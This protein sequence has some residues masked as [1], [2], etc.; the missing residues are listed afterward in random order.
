V[1]DTTDIRRALIYLSLGINN[2][3]KYSLPRGCL[4]GGGRSYSLQDL[5]F[6]NYHLFTGVYHPLSRGQVGESA[7]I[8]GWSDQ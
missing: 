8:A 1:T 2:H 6:V 5:L 3:T 4:T 7:G